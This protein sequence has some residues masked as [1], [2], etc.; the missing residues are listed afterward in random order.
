MVEYSELKFAFF[1]ERYPILFFEEKTASLL[2]IITYR[3]LF[4]SDFHQ[5]K[6]QLQR[7][8]G[9]RVRIPQISLTGIN[10]DLLFAR[11]RTGKDIDPLRVVVVT[12][13]LRIVE[14]DFFHPEIACD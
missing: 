10:R 13:S 9:T 6:S 12:L 11:Q 7:I 2:L 5:Q 4:S 8:N 14:V 3:N 1:P